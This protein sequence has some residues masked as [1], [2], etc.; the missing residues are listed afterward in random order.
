MNYCIYCD[1]PYQPESRYCG[2]CGRPIEI[3]YEGEYLTPPFGHGDYKEYQSTEII[4]NA[5]GEDIRPSSYGSKVEEREVHPSLQKQVKSKIVALMVLASVLI[6]A[7]LF[8]AGY[9]IVSPHFSDDESSSG[10]SVVGEEGDDSWG[11]GE[12]EVKDGDLLNEDGEGRGLEG[13]ATNQTFDIP[14]LNRVISLGAEPRNV[15][16]AI[17]DL[18]TGELHYTENANSPFVATG[19][20]APVYAVVRAYYEHDTNLMG[21]ANDMMGRTVDQVAQMNEDA[22]AIIRGIGDLAGINGR[23][24]SMGFG[25]TN[26]GRLF[27]ATD[28]QNYTSAIEAAQILGMVYQTGG[29][30]RMSFDL[31]AEGIS[32]PE[33]ATFYSHRGT[34]I[35][36]TYNV[37]TVVETPTG[38][39]TVVILTDNMGQSGAVHLVSDVLREVH[40]QMELIHE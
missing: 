12:Q 31:G 13:W 15:A 37:F 19:F 28:G 32:L 21:R 36:E 3:E 39:Y 33:N 35:G 14:E 17:L 34:G 24:G 27:G 26:F 30:R 22:N 8:I 20:Y 40:R 11:E 10:S 16:V 5:Y 4:R 6:I 29:Y 38:N 9:F 1:G 18:N 25:T 23:L 2:L 7:M